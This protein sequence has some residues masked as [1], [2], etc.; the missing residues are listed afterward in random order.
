LAASR[1]RSTSRRSV[2]GSSTTSPPGPKSRAAR[3]R[4]V[5]QPPCTAGVEAATVHFANRNARFAMPAARQ[6]PRRGPCGRVRAPSCLD[7]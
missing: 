3:P 2:R 6:A 4:F 1:R 7:R 5:Q